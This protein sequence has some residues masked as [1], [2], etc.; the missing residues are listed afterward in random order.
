MAKK[1]VSYLNIY[2][3]MAGEHHK[4]RED[5][6]MAILSDPCVAR[7]GFNKRPYLLSDFSKKG[8]GY[9]PCPPADDPDSLATMQREAEGGE[10]ECLKAG[11]KLMLKSTGFGSRRARGREA[12]LHSHLGEGFALD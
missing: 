6:I 5:I 12:D 1:A 10:C 7:Y 3:L 4:A 9:N 11:S 2:S 8:F